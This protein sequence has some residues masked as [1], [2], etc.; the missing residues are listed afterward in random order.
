MRG[1]RQVSR[2]W[3]RL[4][5]KIGLFTLAVGV[6]AG[7]IVLSAVYLVGRHT[8]RETIGTNFRELAKTTAQN[9][10]TQIRHH[11]EEAQLL[12][13]AFSVLQSVEESNAFYGSEPPEEI[14]GR[15]AEIEQRW[16]SAQ[17]V[18]AYLL[19]ILSNRATLHLKRFIRNREE[20]ERVHR[21][22]LVT[23][24]FGA[25]VAS[26]TR[27]G[28]Y[29]YGDREWWQKAMTLGEG[30]VLVAG[31]D[32]DP[33]YP[34][35]TIGIAAP[36]FSEGTVIGVIQMVHDPEPFLR[37]AMS[38]RVGKTDHTMLVSGT[39]KLLYCSA[40]PLD[41]HRLEPALVA[42]IRRET[43]GWAATRVDPHLD[44]RYRGETITG[45]APVPLTFQMGGSNFGGDRWFI[46]TSQDPAETYAP[47]YT[48]LG[49]L[50]LIGVIGTV[51]LFLLSLLAARRIV[52]PIQ[53]LQRGAELVGEGNLN[54]RITIHTG[55]E[56]EKLADQ[57]NRM[58][59]KLKLFY[60][61]LE[62]RVKEKS[63]KLEHQDRELY[64]LYS[65]AAT[66]NKSLTLKELLDETLQKMLEVME[67]DAGVIW[68]SDDVS[69][70]FTITATRVTRVNPP[71]MN[72]LIE[73]I[74]NLS[75]QIIQSGALWTSENL[76]VDERVINMGYADAE[77]LSLAGIPLRSK[78]KVVGVLYLLYREVHAL[79]SRE[80]NLLSSIGSQ[81]GV[82]IDHALLAAKTTPEG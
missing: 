38:A 5:N 80:E 69:G 73:L 6:V 25:V 43:P 71:Q 36:I 9:L 48:L 27:P 61:G 14:R 63:W 31:I 16:Q 34:V 62:E 46:L 45:F 50:A 8:L 57:F 23:N 77:F 54:Y 64:V 65:I 55:D 35:P 44:P 33:D 49:W 11:V 22:I 75:R 26:L 79:T 40:L 3:G 59:Y 29:F 17:G 47:V 74:H 37:P 10:D 18:D 41:Q 56:I 7:A 52:R 30:K 2:I 51:F 53:E 67:A 1:W 78:T 70:R 20:D 12:A 32:T 68:M 60:I 24:K 82:A 13:S 19:E 4:Q 72:N 28:H 39:G 42:E 15:I 81:I 21:Q 66:L 58:A 76:G